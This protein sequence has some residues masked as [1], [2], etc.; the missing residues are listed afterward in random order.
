MGNADQYQIE[1]TMEECKAQ[2]E[3][4]Q[5]LERLAQSPDFHLIIRTGYFRDEPARLAL[6]LA[7]PACEAPDTQA[8]ILRDIHATGSLHTFLNGLKHKASIAERTLA[9]HQELEAEQLR[10][11]L[12]A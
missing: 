11:D 8:R 9:E 12:E 10:A 5:A 7:D 1:V 2:I 3:L 6:L 4:G